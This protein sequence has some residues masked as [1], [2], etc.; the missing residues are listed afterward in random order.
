MLRVNST[1][2]QQLFNV[3][4][5]IC[6]FDVNLSMEKAAIIDDESMCS[7]F[8]MKSKK[9]LFQVNLVKCLKQS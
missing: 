4:K 8:D 5:S 1:L 9:L 6:C 2:V 7:F 3:N